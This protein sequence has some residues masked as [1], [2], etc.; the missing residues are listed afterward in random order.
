M[1]HDN[2]GVI[3]ADNNVVQSADYAG[4]CCLVLSCPSRC[5]YVVVSLHVRQ[6]GISPRHC[7]LPRMKST[8]V[9]WVVIA[10]MQR[11]SPFVHSFI[12]KITRV[13]RYLYRQLIT[14]AIVVVLFAAVYYVVAHVR[15]MRISPRHCDCSGL[16][17]YRRS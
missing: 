14:R 1:L 4:E 7:D 8:S 15:Q 17:Q 5:K 12:I 2:V 6:M 3:L 13:L 11:E 9:E 10:S 16:Q